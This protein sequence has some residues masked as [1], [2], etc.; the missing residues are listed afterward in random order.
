MGCAY[1]AYSWPKRFYFLPLHFHFTSPAASITPP[2]LGSN[3]IPTNE[4]VVRRG[5]QNLDGTADEILPK[6]SPTF[7]SPHPLLIVAEL[8]LPPCATQFITVASPKIDLEFFRKSKKYLFRA[9]LCTTF[10]RTNLHVFDGFLF[11]GIQYQISTISNIPVKWHRLAGFSYFDMFVLCF[12]FFQ[13]SRKTVPFGRILFSRKMTLFSRFDAFSRKMVPFTRISFPRKMIL[14]CR[15][16]IFSPKLI[17]FEA[18]SVSEKTEF[19]A[20]IPTFSWQNFR[21]RR[22]FTS[23]QYLR[24]WAIWSRILNLC[25][26]DPKNK[27]FSNCHKITCNLPI[28]T[29][30]SCTSF[31]SEC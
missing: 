9:R 26:I 28:G 5:R 7:A 16:L 4:T 27:A 29:V 3:V 15:S 6:V 23:F 17:L 12:N 8:T 18:I 21:F 1:H 14:F 2:P 24:F 13:Y 30:G 22:M 10:F 19:F 31:P 11:L 25:V 20:A